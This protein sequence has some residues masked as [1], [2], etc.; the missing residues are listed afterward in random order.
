M[1]R[2]IGWHSL[3]TGRGAPGSFDRRPLHLPVQLIGLFVLSATFRHMIFSLF[4]RSPDNGAMKEALV[5][6][7]LG[8]W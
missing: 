3:I 8:H 2:T 5:M 4:A 6:V 7:S 1:M